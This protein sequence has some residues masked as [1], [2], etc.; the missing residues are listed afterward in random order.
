MTR[1]SLVPGPMQTQRWGQ[2]LPQVGHLI[3]FKRI[4]FENINFKCRM[5]MLLFFLSF[6]FI[7]IVDIY[8]VRKKSIAEMTNLKF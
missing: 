8:T 3:F 7:Y 2:L 5:S 1:L 4:S 6:K